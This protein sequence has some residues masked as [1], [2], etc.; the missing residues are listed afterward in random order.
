MKQED[1]DG[2][3]IAHLNIKTLHDKKHCK[4]HVLIKADIESK[5]YTYITKFVLV[6]EKVHV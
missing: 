1:H 5:S 2:P 3:K 4:L 6:S